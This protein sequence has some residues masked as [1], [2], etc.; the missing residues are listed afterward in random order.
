M[1]KFMVCGKARSEGEEITSDEEGHEY[2]ECWMRRL[3]TRETRQRPCRYIV[4]RFITDNLPDLVL[5]NT[6]CSESLVKYYAG[7]P[8]GKRVLSNILGSLEH[9]NEIS[10]VSKAFKAAQLKSS[11]DKLPQDTRWGVR[12]LYAHSFQICNEAKHELMEIIPAEKARAK[13][14]AVPQI[15]KAKPIP[16]VFS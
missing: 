7:G 5:Y 11:C 4:K 1:K 16:S 13:T 2:S 10:Q 12:Q 9:L 15:P 6:Q 14:A 3:R 8:E